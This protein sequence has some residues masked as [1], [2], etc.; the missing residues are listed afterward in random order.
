MTPKPIDISV[1]SYMNTWP[2][3]YGLQNS[4]EAARVFNPQLD[5]PSEC[6]RK[7][8]NGEVAMGLIP[9]GAL[10]HIPNVEIVTNFC[11]GA[12]DAVHT[13][14]LFSHKPLAEVS[15]VVL[16][17][18]S[19]TSVL[20]TKVLLRNY[21]KKEVTYIMSTPELRYDQIPDDTALLVIGDRCF[22]L[23]SKFDFA[24]DLATAWK[25]FTGLPFAFAVWVSRHDVDKQHVANL[26]DALVWGVEHLD[27]AIAKFDDGSSISVPKIKEY[28]T[29]NI[30]FS[31]TEPRR[32]AIKEFLRLAKREL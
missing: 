6:A 5:Y 2:F 8:I 29:R 27:E 18:Q 22:D 23:Y 7:L 28:L 25:D 9:V 32:Q 10:L 31:L 26:Q 14:T 1:V 19:T 16:D 20:L 21:W 24:T 12:D 17:Y 11:I 4:P 15:K 30:Q 13:V 3:L